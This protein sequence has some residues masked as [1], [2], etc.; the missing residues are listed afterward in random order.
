MTLLNAAAAAPSDA[1]L[2][3]RVRGGDLHAYGELFD[4]HR[5]A[6]YRIA[7]QLARGPDADDLVSEAFAKVLTVLS[8]GGGPDLAFRAYLLT[9][10]RRLHVDRVRSARR[11]QPTDDLAPWDRGVPFQD[12]AVDDFERS[13]ASR[14]FASLPERWQLVLWHLEVEGQKPAEVGVLLGLSANSVSA[15]AYRAREG[16]RQAYL[17]MHL[18]DTAGEACRWTTEHLGGYVRAALSRRDTARVEDHLRECRRC[19]GLYGELAEVND[20][21]RGVLAP[22]VLG[23]AA[24]AYLDSGVVATGG[25][26]APVLGKVGSFLRAPAQALAGGGIAA[27]TAVVVAVA[28]TSMGGG[29][30]NSQSLAGPPESQLPLPT[31]ATTVATARPPVQVRAART[32]PVGGIERRAAVGTEE[33]STAAGGTVPTTSAATGNQLLSTTGTTTASVVPSTVV[34]PSTPLTPSTLVAPSTSVAPTSPEVSTVVSPPTSISPTPTDT[35]V[36]PSP[37]QPSVDPIGTISDLA[38]TLVAVPTGAG[39]NEI[40]AAVTQTRPP[41]H[42]PVLSIDLPAGSTAT[43][44]SHQWSC[45]RTG[46]GDLVCAATGSLAPAVL[47]VAVIYDQPATVTATVDAP[48]NTDPNTANNA[49]TVSIN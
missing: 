25:A 49:A 34:A 14:A 33:R 20:N 10:I 44:Q 22:L 9:A 23:G 40:D 16:L 6:A 39:I 28:T 11:I 15:L 7:R 21:L 4:R 35:S 27:T 42:D 5:D 48:D 43:W 36:D 37:T 29:T 45:E 3:S 2:I 24:A 13:A 26:L 47:A 32:H 19:I 41:A 31:G 38:V 8:T 46:A 30:S 18:A 1:E 12:P 17:R